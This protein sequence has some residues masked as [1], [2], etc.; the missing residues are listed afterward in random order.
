MRATGA[1]KTFYTLRDILS[2][3]RN[4]VV[5]LCSSRLTS[6]TDDVNCFHAREATYIGFHYSA[7]RIAVLPINSDSPSMLIKSSY[8]RRELLPRTRTTINPRWIREKSAK[9]ASASHPIVRNLE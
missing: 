7:T 4:L 6:L 8:S 5:S 9:R 2:V 3:V 1:N